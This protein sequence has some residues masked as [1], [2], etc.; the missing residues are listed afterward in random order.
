MADCQEV[1]ITLRTGAAAGINGPVVFLTKGT[2]VHQ[3]FRG[4]RLHAVFGVPEG[5]CV[6]ANGTGYMDDETWLKVVKILAPA[7]RK[8]K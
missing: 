3:S 5:S 1:F 6:I 7:I 8:M 2:E 4:N